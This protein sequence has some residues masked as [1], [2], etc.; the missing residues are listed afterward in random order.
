MSDEDVEGGAWAKPPNPQE[1]APASERPRAAPAS[2]KGAEAFE[3][4]K[5]G[6][7]HTLRGLREWQAAGRWGMLAQFV[8]LLA[9]ALLVAVVGL[10][11]AGVTSLGLVGTAGLYLGVLALILWLWALFHFLLG[12]RSARRGRDELGYLQR[13]EVDAA[14]ARVLRGLASFAV[15]AIIAVFFGFQAETI[16][17]AGRM[18]DAVL[19]GLITGGLAGAVG[20]WHFSTAV[21]ALLRNLTP[22]A[23]KRGRRRLVALLHVWAIPVM[24]VYLVGAPLAVMN[25]DVSCQELMQCQTG[26]I[27]PVASPAY[28][29]PVRILSEPP[30]ALYLELPLIGAALLLVLRLV[31]YLAM[32]TFSAQL[33]EADH[34]LVRH[35]ASAANALERPVAAA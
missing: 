4:V 25:Y 26:K 22:D 17:R 13:R 16:A 30:A 24:A 23:G 12:L 21:A 15:L 3:S 2:S 32:R 29:A 6:A 27:V 1:P 35:V 14:F 5:N 20:V 10:A 9:A 7:R 11:L 33:A 8:S 18:P 28:G 31:G 34:F 19:Y